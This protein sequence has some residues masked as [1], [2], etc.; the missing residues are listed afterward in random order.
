[1]DTVIIIIGI[2]SRLDDDAIGT[3]GIGGT[4]DGLS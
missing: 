2:F 4:R 1:M 3:G